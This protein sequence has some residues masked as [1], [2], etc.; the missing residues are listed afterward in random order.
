MPIKRWQSSHC[1][2]RGSNASP[3]HVG[4]GRQDEE[5]SA[6]QGAQGSKLKGGLPPGSGLGG[7]STS[8]R[9]ACRQ[10][11]ELDAGVGS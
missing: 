4:M 1:C 6:S 5:E 2:M 11:K 10:T 9:P 7:G 8:H 3:K